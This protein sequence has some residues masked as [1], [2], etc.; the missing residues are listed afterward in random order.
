[1]RPLA[2][3][4]GARPCPSCSTRRIMVVKS[5]CVIVC[6][7]AGIAYGVTQTPIEMAPLL[8]QLNG[9]LSTIQPF[10]RGCEKRQVISCKQRW[11]IKITVILKGLC[12]EYT[13]G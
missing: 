8:Q 4:T 12:D 2:T 9:S 6:P 10:F 11:A 7:S 13:T 1:M 5:S 3:V